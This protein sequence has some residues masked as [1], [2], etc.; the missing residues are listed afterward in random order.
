MSKK[1]KF[2]TKNPELIA[3]TFEE[4]FKK[5][6]AEKSNTECLLNK[7]YEI[8]LTSLS[9]LSIKLRFLTNKEA[10]TFFE[11]FSLTLNRENLTKILLCPSKE[12]LSQYFPKVY[13][14]DKKYEFILEQ[15]W[16][17]FMV[18]FWNRGSFSQSK[19]NTP[20]L[21][22][23]DKS[24]HKLDA[25]EKIFVVLEANAGIT[26]REDQRTAIKEICASIDNSKSTVYQ[27]TMGGGKT[28]VFGTFLGA[29][30]AK[31]KHLL[32][33]YIFPSS[34]LTTNV[35]FMNDRLWKVFGMKLFSLQMKR[36]PHFYSLDYLSFVFYQLV[37]YYES[38]DGAIICSPQTIQCF[39]NARKELLNKMIETEGEERK[40][41]CRETRGC[42]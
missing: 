3:Q 11:R 34:I 40:T 26:I 21:H 2:S 8:S 1:K 4:A 30:A 32:P 12:K 14:D 37:T 28:S 19:P 17:Y 10:S 39:L 20:E 33:V 29:Y 36:S 42:D 18:N 9:L 41:L 23:S 27:W 13:L 38:Q 22:S 7:E 5:I 35:S 15:Y 16:Q 25:I 24:T 31:V 6:K